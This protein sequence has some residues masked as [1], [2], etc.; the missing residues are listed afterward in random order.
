MGFN[1]FCFH[2]R[3]IDS[4][5]NDYIAALKY[6][7]GIPS[8]S[9]TPERRDD[10]IAM[11]T[12]TQEKLKNLGAEVELC[13]V[14]SQKL[15]DGRVIKLPP[16]LLGTLGK[17]PKKPTVCVY[18][19]LDVQ[20]AAKE[21]GWDTEPFTLTEKDG[22]LFGRGA[23]D[24]KG[25]VLCWIHA[26][27][28]FQETGCDLPVNVKFCFEGMEESGSEG[29]DDL[30]RERKDS[31][32]KDVDYVCV[33][34]NYWLGRNKPCLTYGLRGLCYF[35][36]EVECACKD[37]HSGVYGGAVNEAMGDLL[38]VFSSLVDGKGNILIPHLSD[39]VVPVTE[40]EKKIYTGIDFSVLDYKNEIGSNQLLHNEDKTKILMSRWRYPSLSIHGIE[41][42]FSEPG[43][44]TVIP[45]KVIGKFSIRI[46]PNQ[47]PEKV[48]ECVVKYMNC[49]WN[50]RGS[51]NNF[52][53]Y[54]THGAKPWM[55]D[56]N[57]KNYQAAIKATKHV[58][59][60]EPD[61]TREGGS[62]PVT[63]TLQ[64]VTGKNVIL[65]PVGACDDGAHSQNE[66]IDIRN[67]IEGVSIL[68]ILNGSCTRFLYSWNTIG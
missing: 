2:F 47:V 7:V 18:G 13:D 66:K 6:A 1:T 17:D 35:N 28:A 4:N 19:H 16:V 25:P 50:K 26:I 62:I 55:S 23:S 68:Y 9:G 20:P 41:G 49:V 34:D 65:I 15:S 64:E 51:K 54:M 48:E 43:S 67:Y 29:L 31:F 45:R 14:G 21:D 5:K 11:V 8:V 36:V 22:K 39:D 57:H 44:K 27:R 37:L 56:P 24:D 61:L 60:V 38:H 59:K 30:L 12:W 42:A 63:L 3:C 46:V 52:K 33:S 40:D 58:Y 53:V 32:F 10:V